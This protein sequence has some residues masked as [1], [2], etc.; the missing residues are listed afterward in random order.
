VSIYLDLTREFNAGRLR[1]I[2]CSGQAVVMLR[3]AIASKD[4]DWI[5]REEQETLDHV[6]AVLDRRGARYRFGAPL[7]LRWLRAGWSSHF[8]FQH[9]G[10]RVRT[11]FFTRPPRVSPEDLERLWREQEERDPPFTPPRMLIEIK[12]TARE[13]DWPIV[14]E[15]A[16]LLSD[17]RE[18]MLCSRSAR[19][20][21]ALAAAHPG[22]AAELAAVR[23]V[24]GTVPDGV[25]AL[26]EALDRERREAMEADERRI[27]AYVAAATGLE[28]AWPEV[29]AATADRRLSSAHPIVVDWA[30]R[31]LPTAPAWTPPATSS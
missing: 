20:L 4:G 3:L 19:D 11:D 30:E 15:L 9:G 17:P 6:L 13:K 24:L 5:L 26:H 18:Q 29:Q 12:K 10:L 21:I 23:P 27:R 22:L 14:G 28:R 1:A 16:R 31:C 25:P 8:Q 7:D 2:L